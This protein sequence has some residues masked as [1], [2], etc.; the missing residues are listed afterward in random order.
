MEKNKRKNG[1]VGLLIVL[2]FFVGAYF[3]GQIWHNDIMENQQ[4]TTGTVYKT[5]QGYRGEVGLQ[6][7][8]QIGDSTY[9]GETFLDIYS[10]NDS[11]FI[12]KNFPVIFSKKTNR[13]DM[14]VLPKDFKNFNLAFPDSL[15][16]VIDSVRGGPLYE[17]PHWRGT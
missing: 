3:Y 12:D 6:Y 15:H 1:I 10:G 5:Y 4:P 11:L 13:N 14:L 16:W 8:F 17:L 7:K 9:Y 2:T